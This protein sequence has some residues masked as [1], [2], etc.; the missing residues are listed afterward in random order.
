MVRTRH[1][2]PVWKYYKWLAGP[3][4]RSVGGILRWGRT[5]QRW[6]AETGAWETVPGHSLIRSVAL[7]DPMT[8]EITPDE[9]TALGAHIE[10]PS[11]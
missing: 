6:D 8:I 10:A 4:F 9:A 2:V 7:G 11:A 5:M 1:E 3:D